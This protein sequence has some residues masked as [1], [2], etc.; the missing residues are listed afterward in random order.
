M[1]VPKWYGGAMPWYGLTEWERL[2][3]VVYTLRGNT[4]PAPYLAAIGLRLTSPEHYQA[5]VAVT[6]FAAETGVENAVQ[7]LIGAGY[8]QRVSE[9]FAAD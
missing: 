6:R 8:L 9:A 5:V 2:W 4:D 7:W 3:E 1:V